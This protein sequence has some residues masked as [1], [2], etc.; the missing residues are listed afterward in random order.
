ML[1]ARWL[2][3]FVS[4]FLMVTANAIHADRIVVENICTDSYETCINRQI[5]KCENKKAYR[6][7]RSS[8]MRKLA[9]LSGMKATYLREYKR[10]LINDMVQDQTGSKSYQIQY[11]L[12][13][14]FFDIARN[15]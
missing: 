14:R 8:E 3:V 4:M 9:A 1:K 5:E 15:K 7:S 13:K 2:L 12:N 11:Y 10:E 6:C